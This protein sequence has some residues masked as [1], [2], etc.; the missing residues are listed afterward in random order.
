MDLMEY[1]TRIYL[2]FQV[3]VY[4]LKFAQFQKVSV[5]DMQYHSDSVMRFRKKKKKARNKD[6]F[7]EWTMLT[8]DS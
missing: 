5:V 6:L 1:N 2:H 3:S 4:K 7:C 8:D